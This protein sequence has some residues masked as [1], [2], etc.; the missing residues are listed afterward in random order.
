MPWSLYEVPVTFLTSFTYRIKIFNS[1]H[2]SILLSLFWSKSK[3]FC[4]KRLILPLRGI[5]CFCWCLCRS[6][7]G[8][9]HGRH[10]MCWCK[11]LK[12]EKRNR[13]LYYSILQLKHEITLTSIDSDPKLLDIHIRLQAV[14]MH[15]ITYNWWHLLIC[16]IF[17]VISIFSFI[18]CN[19]CTERVFLRNPLLYCS[20]IPITCIL[21]VS[22]TWDIFN[23]VGGYS[24]P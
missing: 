17:R 2:I 14:K 19:S 21:Y 18:W 6:L 9:L 15:Y 8:H 24:T 5:G 13:S 20:T 16:F 23:K 10:C 11:E 12:E 3:Q 22:S 1:Q 7:H 4:E